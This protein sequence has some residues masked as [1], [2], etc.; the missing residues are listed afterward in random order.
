[1]IKCSSINEDSCLVYYFYEYILEMKAII[2]FMKTTTFLFGES[3]F[4][5]IIGQTLV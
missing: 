4:I 5:R 3:K 2:Q 1:M